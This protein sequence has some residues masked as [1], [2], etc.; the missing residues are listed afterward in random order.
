MLTSVSQAGG[1]STLS[2]GGLGFL[3]PDHNSFINPGQFALDQGGAFQAGY[4]TAS[5]LGF[6]VVSVTP[7]FVWGNGGRF[8]FG[9]YGNRAG[10]SLTDSTGYTDSVGAGMGVALVKEKLTLGLRGIRDLSTGAT[11]DGTVG[12]SLNLNG[13]KRN[14]FTAG[15]GVQTTLNQAVAETRVATAALGYGFKSTSAVEAVATLN[16]IDDTNDWSM[17][18]YLNLSG[19]MFYFSG[20]ASYGNLL[21]NT[22]VEGRAGFV[23]GNRFDVS[24]KVVYPLETGGIPV[25]GG[26][27]RLAF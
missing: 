4:D 17:A 9:V 2:R 1:K 16:N 8:G 20:G 21:Q 5:V 24:A 10:I 25:Y 11:S 22:S 19:Q 18:G 23:L 12:A 27:A 6:T 13:S 15:V 7:S 26:T 3:F 14:G